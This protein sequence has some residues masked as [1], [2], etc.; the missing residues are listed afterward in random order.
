MKTTASLAAPLDWSSKSSG[1]AWSHPAQRAAA[2]LALTKPRI[3]VMVLLTVAVGYFLG[4]R[5]SA[6]PSALLLTLTG[7]GLVAAGASVWNQLLER[8]RDARMRRTAG[9]PLPTGRVQVTEA[10]AFGT[11]T[12][13]LGVGMLALGPHPLAAGVAAATFILYAFVYTPLKP[14]TTLNTAVG[15]IPGALPP[16]IGW[17]AATGKLGLEAAALFLIVFLWQFPHFLAIAWLYRDDYRRGGFRMLPS[18]DD[19]KGSMTGRQAAGHAL[20]LLPV[21]LLPV[22]IG[23]AGP[24]YFVGALAVGIYY[25]AAA[26]RFWLAVSDST[27]R[28]LLRASFIHLLGIL[29]LLVSNPLPA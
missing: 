20:A 12:A 6:D 26:S 24:A 17:S 14:L 13:I 28:H 27:A 10:A 7:T 29:L 1:L 4:A 9:R 15:A 18:A 11:L 22:A 19:A 3:V 25:L 5:R 21:G 16:V 23:M 8:T 2:F